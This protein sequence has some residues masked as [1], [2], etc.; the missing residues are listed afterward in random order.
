MQPGCLCLVIQTLQCQRRPGMYMMCL[1]CV[2]ASRTAVLCCNLYSHRARWLQP[3]RALL[4]A[5]GASW[6]CCRGTLNPSRSSRCEHAQPQQR[7]ALQSLWAA[8]SL[9][10]ERLLLY[11]LYACYMLQRCLPS[12]SLM[13]TPQSYCICIRLG[14]SLLLPVFCALT[15]YRLAGGPG[16]PSTRPCDA[17]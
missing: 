6:V 2:Y 3:A 10:H 4:A 7:K 1:S 17:C 8:C 11:G 9:V 5:P 14:C 15:L 12:M 16:W 13:H